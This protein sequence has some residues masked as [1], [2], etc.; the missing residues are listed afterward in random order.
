MLTLG[1]PSARFRTG[2][3]TDSVALLCRPCWGE[4][5]GWLMVLRAECS[6]DKTKLMADGG[7]GGGGS[8]GN[9]RTALQDTCVRVLSEDILPDTY[10]NAPDGQTL[11]DIR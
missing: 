3:G 7:R 4:G 10:C 6:G 2:A 8:H 9:I 11:L 5:E 1:A